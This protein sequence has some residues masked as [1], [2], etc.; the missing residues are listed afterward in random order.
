MSMSVREDLL[1]TRRRSWDRRLFTF[2]GWPRRENFRYKKYS[3]NSYLWSDICNMRLKLKHWSLN[4]SAGMCSHIFRFTLWFIFCVHRKSGS[5]SW[6]SSRP[7][8]FT[9]EKDPA[10]WFWCKWYLWDLETKYSEIWGQN[11]G[12]NGSCMFFPAS[13]IRTCS[14][15]INNK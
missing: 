15:N 13:A 5:F 2:E 4:R 11:L 14:S 6:L 7:I 10:I 1:W 12:T 8:N 9:R 3:F